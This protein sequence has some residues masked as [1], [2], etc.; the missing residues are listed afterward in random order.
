[1]KDT[2]EQYQAKRTVKTITPEGKL[3]DARIMLVSMSMDKGQFSVTV[4][5]K[6]NNVY[7][8]EN[9][10]MYIETSGCD[11]EADNINAELVIT[12]NRKK[13]TGSITFK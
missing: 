2:Y 3:I 8:L 10:K 4:T 5:K 7:Y 13:T 12:E 6:G 1:V 9:I 11:A